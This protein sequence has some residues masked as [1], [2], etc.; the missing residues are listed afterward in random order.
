LYILIFTFLGSRREDKR[1]WTEWYQALPEFSHLLISSWIE[2]WFITEVY[3]LLY[4]NNAAASSLFYSLIHLRSHSHLPT[5]CE[6]RKSLT[7]LLAPFII[8]HSFT[9]PLSDSLFLPLRHAPSMSLI[10]SFTRPLTLIRT[11]IE[12]LLIIHTYTFTQ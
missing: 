2:F 9:L 5:Q 8:C 6:T 12:V 10:H 1:F 11:L 4:R 3:S 7:Q